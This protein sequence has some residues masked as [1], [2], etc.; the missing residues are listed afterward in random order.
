M[1]STVPTLRDSRT[2]PPKV[3]LPAL[4]QTAWF[5][6]SPHGFLE[7]NAQRL[8]PVFR[9]RILGFGSGDFAFVSDPALIE[10]VFTHRGSNLLAGRAAYTTIEP[11]GGA[12]SLLVLDP[13]RHL[14]E[15]KLMLPAFHGDRMRSYRDVIAE[16]TRRSIASWPSGVPFPLR[17]RFAEIA[18]DVIMRAVFGLARGPNYSDLRAALLSVVENDRMISLAL[19][20]PAI[21]RDVGPWRSWSN[22]RRQIRAADHLIFREIEERWNDPDLASRDDI[23][24]MLLLARRDDGSALTMEELRDELVTMLLAGH[25]TTAT[26]LAWTF[27]QLFH[28]PHVLEE[29]QANV[30][31]GAPDPALIDAVIY[32]ALRVR[33]VI[34]F[35]VRTLTEPWELAGFELPAGC[36]VAPAI[37]AV[38]RDPRVYPDP[39]RFDPT[40][41]LERRPGT[42][43]W[44]PF[45][46]GTR[47]CI[48]ASFA[49][50]EMRTVL[51]TVLAETTLRPNSDRPER[52]RRRAFMLVPAHGTPAVRYPLQ[53]AA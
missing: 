6:K 48:G 43:E 15:R 32:E 10:R 11:V 45:G 49:L 20:L 35:V 29:L 18:L 23:L 36:T 8:G 17:P 41:F 50:F 5:L 13:P 16:E 38:H 51:E 39:G 1:V 37:Y 25:E 46:G 31:S 52:I 53:T 7:D 33:P 19:M 44:L 9:A 34:P 21:R 14:E 22:F 26:A 2:L 30:A 28:N 42:Y 47:R 4:A 24:S 3:R 27:D 12:N 40:R